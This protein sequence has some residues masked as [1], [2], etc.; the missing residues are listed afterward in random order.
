MYV[1]EDKNKEQP[2]VQLNTAWSGGGGVVFVKV[3]IAV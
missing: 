3:K 1:N 2:S